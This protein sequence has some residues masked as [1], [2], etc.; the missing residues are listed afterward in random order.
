MEPFKNARTIFDIEFPIFTI[1]L[2]Y[3][4]VWT[5]DNVTYI[6]TDSGVY[7]LDNKNIDGNTLG[8]RRLR[9]KNSKLYIP[10]KVIHSVG[11]LVRSK[12]KTFLDNDGVLFKYYKTT[13]VPLKYL[14]VDRVVDTKAGCVLHFKNFDHPEIVSCRVAYGIKYVGYLVT[15]VGY[16]LYE[17]SDSFKGDTW[18][19]V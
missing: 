12:Y 16:I 4:R 11:Q 3:K 7:V 14:K 19:K 5:E 2:T 6:E 17:Y 18:R 10:R 15:N 1:A 13:I 8:Q 9:I